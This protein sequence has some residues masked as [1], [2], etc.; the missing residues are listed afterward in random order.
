MGFDRTLEQ[1]EDTMEYNGI[2]EEFGEPFTGR[3]KKKV[4][5]FLKKSDLD[6]DEQIEFTVNLVN[7][8]GE[9]AATGSLHENVLKCIAVD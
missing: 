5:E 1:Q 3:K 8:D 6:Y 7:Q 4:V 9:I 2:Y